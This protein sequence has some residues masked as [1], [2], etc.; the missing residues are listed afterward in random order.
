MCEVVDSE[1]ASPRV[2]VFVDVCGCVYVCEYV[3]VGV[4]VVLVCVCIC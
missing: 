2:C 4:C 3:C 1:F